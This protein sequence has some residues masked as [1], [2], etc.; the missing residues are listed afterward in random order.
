M[1]YEMRHASVDLVGIG[2]YTFA[3]ADRLIRVPAPK[4]ARWL[5]GHEANG[6][7]YEALWRP[8]VDLGEMGFSSAF[9]TCRKRASPRPSSRRV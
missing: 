8:Q 2:L 6:L 4:I 5:R 1:N 7:R 3:E 9:A